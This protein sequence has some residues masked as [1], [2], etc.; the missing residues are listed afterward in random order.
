MLT[1]EQ[2]ACAAAPEL[3]GGDAVYIG[4]ALPA[5]LSALLTEGVRRV[6]SAAAPTD[7]AFVRAACVSIRGAYAADELVPRARRVIAVLDVPLDALREHLRSH[8][9]GAHSPDGLVA[10]VVSPDASLEL[11]P[12]GLRLRHVARGVS[13]RDNFS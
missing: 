5:G 2:L 13:A 9:D 12:S 10:R 4:P 8:C 7:L 1:A 3:L 6:E 11:L